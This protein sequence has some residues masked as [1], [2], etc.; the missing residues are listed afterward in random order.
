MTDLLPDNAVNGGW[1]SDW[2]VNLPPIFVCSINWALAACCYN[3]ICGT[4]SSPIKKQFLDLF[5]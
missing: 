1:C 5:L 3:S 2:K 4:N